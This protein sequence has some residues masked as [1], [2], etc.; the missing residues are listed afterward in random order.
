MTA[1]QT[2]T[3]GKGEHRHRENIR[4]GVL[5]ATHVSR[6]RARANDKSRPI[7]Q[8]SQLWSSTLS[9]NAHARI[10]F[11]ELFK[12]PAVQGHSCS[13]VSKTADGQSGQDMH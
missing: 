6:D 11:G 3:G 13:I 5:R 8:C 1:V 4:E 10:L 2:P 7:A 9:S 12:R